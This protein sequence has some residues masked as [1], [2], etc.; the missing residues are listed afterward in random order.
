VHFVDFVYQYR[1]VG[2]KL[3]VLVLEAHFIVMLIIHFAL[4]RCLQQSSSLL[5]VF[6]VVAIPIAGSYN[7]VEMMSVSLFS[8]INRITVRNKLF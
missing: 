4:N 2:R 3:V 6:Q 5:I 1:L 8:F 7:L